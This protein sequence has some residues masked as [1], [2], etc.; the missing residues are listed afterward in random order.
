MSDKIFINGL[1]VRRGDKAP[2]FVLCDANFKLEEFYEFMKGHVDK[3]G[4]VNTTIKKSQAGKI[5]C[6]L[7]TY[8]PSKE[9][10]DEVKEDLSDDGQSIPF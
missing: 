10:M 2:D 3:E 8:K 6:E 5:Y 9:Q 1:Y 7:N 4:Y